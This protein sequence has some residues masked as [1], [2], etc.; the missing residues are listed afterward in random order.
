VHWLIVGI[1]KF[2]GAN[3][4]GKQFMK[5]LVDLTLFCLDDDHVG[6]AMRYN[7]KFVTELCAAFQK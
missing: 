6:P 5:T 2:I 3:K 7:L 1:S 4:I